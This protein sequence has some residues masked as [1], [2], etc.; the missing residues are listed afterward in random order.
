[1]LKG[2]R[3]SR[4]RGSSIEFADYRDYSQGDDLRRL[5]WN[6]FA[7]LE[8]P[9]VKLLED[10]E[11]L[12]VHILIDASASMD[13]P[14]EDIKKSKF[15]YAIRLAGA[16]GYISLMV[17]DPV[18]VAW[19]S[20]DVTRKWGPHRGRQNALSLFQYLEAGQA[21][22]R[23]NINQATKN[24]GLRSYRPGLLI[25]ITDLLSPDGYKPGFKSLLSRG[26]E[27]IIL[28]V[29]SND[30]INPVMGGDVKLVDKETGNSAELSL[31]ALTVSEFT[32]RFRD[33]QQEIASFSA[34]NAIHYLSVTT[35]TPWDKLVFHSLR[36][37]K[38]IR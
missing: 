17:G 24:Y 14:L 34:E 9:F 35:D 8:R 27:L 19:L 20:E 25:L 29:L 33:W 15:Q 11:D 28:Q 32:D 26:Y 6:V 13:W 23:T 18:T 37:R 16:L 12:A 38:I 10:E 1:L 5:D 36:E 22:G 30:E 21:Q 31:D 4:K 3:R 2:E 7:R